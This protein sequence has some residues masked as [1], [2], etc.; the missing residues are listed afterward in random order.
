MALPAGTRMPAKSFAAS[1][2]AWLPDATTLTG[3]PLSVARS[4]EVVLLKPNWYWPLTTPGMIAAPPWASSVFSSRPSSAKKPLSIPRYT[5]AT[6]RIGISPTVTV[7][8]AAAPAD[9]EVPDESSPEPHPAI[10]RAVAAPS[11]AMLVRRVTTRRVVRACMGLAPLRVRRR[12]PL[13]AWRNA[14]IIVDNF[15]NH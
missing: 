2:V 6:S 12:S 7:V 5:G 11:A 1:A 4:S 9:V 3:R 15:V 14:S 8:V 10:S 13:R